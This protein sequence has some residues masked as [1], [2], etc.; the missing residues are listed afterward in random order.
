M[1]KHVKF[2]IIPLL[3]GAV[4]C[5]FHGASAITKREIINIGILVKF[6]DSENIAPKRADGTPLHIDDTDSLANAELLLNSDNPIT[7]Q[8][9]L[10]A[11]SVPSIKK[12][13][14]TQSYGKLS[15]TTKFFIYQDQH[16]MSYYSSSSDSQQLA[17]E[18]ELVNNAI[19]SISEQ[20]IASGITSSTLDSNNDGKID[21]LTLFIEN[22]NAPAS[23][24]FHSHVYNNSGNITAKIAN[25][26]I[27]AHSIIYH[28]G[29]IDKYGTFS[30][31]TGGY[32]TIA[33]E[34]GHIL[35]FIDLYRSDH[36]GEPVGIYDL[37]GK[38]SSSNPQNI[39]AY[40]VSEYSPNTNWHNPLPV[41]SQTTKN[42]T[43][44]RPQFTNP[45]EQ[46]AIKIQRNAN[47]QEYFIVEYYEPHDARDG[48]AAK[49]RG[50]I[51]Y[52]INNQTNATDRVFVF[53]P[54][55]PS[56]NAARGDLLQ[57]PLNL[58]R[59]SLGKGLGT[60]KEFDNQ[61]IYYSDGT[62]SGITITVTKMDDN[63]VTFDIVFPEITGAGTQQSPYQI[64]DTTTFLYLMSGDTK[65]KYY[66]ITKDLD[67][68]KIEHP[69][70]NFYGHLDGQNHT[71]S[72]IISTGAGIF[73]YLGDYDSPSSIK[74]LKITNLTVKPNSIGGSLGGLASAISSSTISNVHLL[75]G[76]VNNIKGLNTLSATG[77]FAGN[78][79]ST[80]T[81]DSC[82]SAISVKANTNVGGFIGLNQNA[83]ISNSST[84]G[85]VTGNT[86]IGSFIG[87]QYLTDDAYNMP[88]NVT[89]DSKVNGTIPVVGTT[90]DANANKFITTPSNMLQGITDIN[91][92]QT[93]EP[94]KPTPTPKPEP[95]LTEAEVL[96]K[97][98]LTK[99][100]NY[101]FGFAINT[102][103]SVIRQSL[104][105]IKG[106]E[107]I[108]IQSN[109]QIITTHT[110]L[111]LRIGNTTYAYIVVLK[112]DVNGDGK[113]QATDYV[114]IRN[115][116]MGKTN[117]TD[118]SLQAADINQDS[119][120]QATDYVKVRNHIMGK[121]TINQ[122]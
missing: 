113:I 42:I 25:K 12:Y 108:N 99:K 7:M 114:K 49:E 1:K 46:R 10:G 32:G 61:T 97:L 118:A 96:R 100:Q 80:T 110:K 109:E 67:F 36:Q 28:S 70:I 112:G 79:D 75:S 3:I 78:V 77:G 90:Y 119:K 62:N 33:H 115:H 56:L 19:N 105:N 41:I 58:N 120:V 2:L 26:P 98:N 13:Y 92:D 44:S 23:G 91:S 57:A 64:S 45:S 74:N 81:I 88:Q 4:F 111:S 66:T 15:I 17:R 84:T 116:I 121:S 16:P 95:T 20:V 87:I 102:S 72:N 35:G 82:T 48:Y 51:I 47:D 30:L 24:I 68:S 101:L 107:I 8:T 37:M 31:D 117:L 69:R 106:L 9:S 14:E 93:T 86:N 59:P 89:Y 65:G 104:N 52:R 39:L 5:I 63:S 22:S 54:N 55:E 18:N 76:E 29:S 53:R 73:D 34:L 94:E 71:L 43:V 11:I 40:L 38:N 60:S 27:A 83:K 103:I 85:K 6:A 122:K 50:I 21:M